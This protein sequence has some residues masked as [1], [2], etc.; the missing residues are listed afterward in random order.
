[1]KLDTTV[2]KIPRIGQKTVCI[3]I[4]IINIDLFNIPHKE[5]I[6]LDIIQLITMLT[7]LS[8]IDIYFLFTSTLFLT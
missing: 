2:I 4:M 8:K 6:D 3:Q 5:T 7:I 1:M